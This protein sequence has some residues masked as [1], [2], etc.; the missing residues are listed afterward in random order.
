MVYKFSSPDAS[1]GLHFFSKNAFMS[2]KKLTS[3]KSLHS[4]SP[5]NLFPQFNLHGP[6][7][8]LRKV[9]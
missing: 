8:E 2:S 4:F 7:R 3:N 1:L 9:K 6:A 5:V